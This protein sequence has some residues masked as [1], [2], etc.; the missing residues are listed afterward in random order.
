MQVN[1]THS[2]NGLLEQTHLKTITLQWGMIEGGLLEALNKDFHILQN[3]GRLEE[4]KKSL[5]KDCVNINEGS[6]SAILCKL[7]KTTVCKESFYSSFI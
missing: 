3:T 5:L 4:K 1:G 2:K 6:G 7:C